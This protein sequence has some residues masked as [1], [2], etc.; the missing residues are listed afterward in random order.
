M[1]LQE[2][3]KKMEAGK[4]NSANPG[5]SEGIDTAKDEDIAIITDAME[6]L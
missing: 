6:G 4:T 5:Y 1:V 3:R 2:L